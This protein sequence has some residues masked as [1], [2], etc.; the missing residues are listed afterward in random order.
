MAINQSDKIWHNGK[1]I[2]WDQATIHVMSHVVNYGSSVFEGIRC[3]A[4]P[5]GPAVFRLQKHMQRPLDPPKIYRM[6]LEYTREEL[7][8]GVLDVVQAN[9]GVPGYIRP[10]VLR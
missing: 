3:Y 2:P 10:I 9:R 4:P 6:D 7:L 1:L 5:A 8:Q